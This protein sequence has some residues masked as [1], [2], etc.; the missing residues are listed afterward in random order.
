MSPV[1]AELLPLVGIGQIAMS[2][3]AISWSLVRAQGRNAHATVVHFVGNWCISTT[4]GALMIILF[5]INLQ[6]LLA[7]LILG[8]TI[9]GFGYV[10]ILNRSQWDRIAKLMAASYQ[11]DD[12]STY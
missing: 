6:G 12:P 7:A 2:I 5:R 9:G 11:V 8:Y 1:F 10:Y 4:M 3:S